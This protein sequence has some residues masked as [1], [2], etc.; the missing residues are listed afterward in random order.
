MKLKDNDLD[1]SEQKYQTLK[2]IISYDNDIEAEI[3]QQAE[4]AGVRLYTYE[5]V[6]MEGERNLSKFV[7]QEPVED[8][9]F[10]IS[11]TSGTTGDPKG[12]KITH[13]AVMTHILIS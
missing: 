9:V 6:L 1:P 11:F 4:K 12:V 5:Y 7:I 10:T 8:D 13:K 3:M 2:Y